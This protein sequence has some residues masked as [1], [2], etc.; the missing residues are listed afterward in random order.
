MNRLISFSTDAPYDEV[1][2]SIADGLAVIQ[3]AENA[4]SDGLQIGDAFV[5]LS[6]EDE[7]REIIND[8]SEFLAQIKNL[9]PE[10]AKSAML[11]A[12]NRII[13][14]G[15]ELR[16]IT[17]FL[18]NALWGVATGFSDSVSIL[19]M[20]QRQVLEKQALFSGQNIFPPLLGA[21]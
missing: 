20:G 17:K 13:G 10:T 6:N 12:G 2:D 15:K 11:E 3:D 7:V 21:A 16:N 14:N 9:S 19:Q 8:S 18:L 5:L 4:L 1:A